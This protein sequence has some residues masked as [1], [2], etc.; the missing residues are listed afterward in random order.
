MRYKKIQ[1]ETN[2]FIERTT[3]DGVV[4]FIPLNELNIDYQAYLASLDEADS[5]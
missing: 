3:D 1:I 2:E 4:S 5:L